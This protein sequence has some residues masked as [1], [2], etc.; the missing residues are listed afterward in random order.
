M[1]SSVL[2]LPDYSGIEMRLIAE[3]S[4]EEEL[5]TMFKND[6]I[7]ADP[8]TIAAELF[9]G[10]IFTDMDTC[11]K[12]FKINP[13]NDIESE[14]KKRKK[15]LRG[16]A[17]NASFA[18]AYIAKLPKL[19]K[20]LMLTYEQAEPGYHRYRDR[21]PKVFYYSEGVLK[22]AREKGYVETPFGPYMYA[23]DDQLYILG[24]YKIQHMA[25]KILKRA[26]VKCHYYFKKFFNGEVKIILDIHDELVIKFPRKFL[27]RENEFIKN[28]TQL[29]IDCKEI[30]VPLSV[31]WKM[32][33]TTWADAKELKR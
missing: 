4:G 9:Y 33:T 12:F 6:P 2:Y 18:K 32:T 20:T 14:Y 24:N 27:F 16:A 7:N 29:M 23:P 10:D 13:K 21:W 28:T 17:K 3:A 15:I 26:I 8:H 25:A 22:E 30:T 11:F 5:I 19:L 31:E 1:S